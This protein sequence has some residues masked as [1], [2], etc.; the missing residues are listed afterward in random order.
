MDPGARVSLPATLVEALLAEFPQWNTKNLPALKNFRNILVRSH[1]ESASPSPVTAEA[2]GSHTAE[3]FGSSS[4]GKNL[5]AGNSSDN[6]AYLPN[7]NNSVSV[8][9]RGGAVTRAAAAKAKAKDGGKCDKRKANAS[10]RGRK[11][12]L[13]NKHAEASERARAAM[14]GGRPCPFRLRG[15][16]ASEASGT[17]NPGDTGSELGDTGSEPAEDGE[18]V[19]VGKKRK[20][21]GDR[22]DFIV[23]KRPRKALAQGGQLLAYLAAAHTEEG[24]ASVDLLVAQLCKPAGAPS[25]EAEASSVDVEVGEDF[26]VT[27][28]KNCHRP[29]VKHARNE[30]DLI[31]ALV[32]LRLASQRSTKPDVSIAKAAG[33]AAS[34][35]ATYKQQGTRLLAFAGGGTFYVLILIAALG[36]RTKIGAGSVLWPDVDSAANTLRDP[37]AGDTWSETVIAY[38]IPVIQRLHQNKALRDGLVFGKTAYKLNQLQ[39]HMQLKDVEIRFS[40]LELNDAL[41]DLLEHNSFKQR[42][43]SSHWDLLK[44]Q[45]MISPKVSRI[46]PVVTIKTNVRLPEKYE[47]PVDKYNR[48]EK[49]AEFR[50]HAEKAPRMQDLGEYQTNMS[51]MYEDGHKPEGNVDNFLFKNTIS[52]EAEDG[53]QLALVVTHMRTVLGEKIDAIPALLSTA[54][55]DGLVDT[56]SRAEDY[57]FEAIH[58]S[59]YNRYAEDGSKAPKDAHPDCVVREKVTRVNH[60]QRLPHPLEQMVREPVAYDLLKRNLADIVSFLAENISVHRPDLVEKLSAR[61][62]FLPGN[63]KCPFAPYGGVVVNMGG[64]SDAHTDELDDED[65][66][67]VIPFTRNCVGGALV[68]HEAGTVLDLHA[69]DMVLFLSARLTH[70][71]LHFQGIRASLV[72]HTDMS[73]KLWDRVNGWDGQYGVQ[74]E[75]VGAGQ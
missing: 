34:S 32:Q 23:A 50:E 60:G 55:G 11:N 25:P 10:S 36:I 52:I 13:S 69:G 38:I 12:A 9:L 20:R 39:S 6:D 15:G 63:E 30:F 56:D 66:C 2:D 17:P 24:Q 61:I 4:T 3:T 7:S 46:A 57:T 29:H 14:N 28:A 71:N 49:T 18:Y 37:S 5:G 74:K 22:G 47:S 64:C 21:K 72:F 53:V 70:F 26:C 8:R 67:V 33:I 31:M 41:T 40:N 43:R 1:S 42:S 35:L 59:V 62:R 68:L 44:S 73:L 48:K 27:M 58:F 75:G 54:L 19:D 65:H 51:S 45:P 16:A